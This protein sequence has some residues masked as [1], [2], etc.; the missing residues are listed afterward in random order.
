YRATVETR[1]MPIKKLIAKPGA[2]AKLQTKG[3][4]YYHSAEGNSGGPAGFKAVNIPAKNLLTMLT[5][6]CRYSTKD[7]ATPY[8]DESGLQGNIDIEIDALM[9]DEEQIRHALQKYGLDI[10][11]AYKPMQVV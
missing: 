7:Y 4:P 9:L 8:L 2:Q 6:Y 1:M 10:V 3:G 11:K 5:A